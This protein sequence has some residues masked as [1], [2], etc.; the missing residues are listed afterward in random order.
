MTFPHPDLTPIATTGVAS[1]F[2]LDFFPDCSVVATNLGN[3]VASQP[4]PL[5]FLYNKVADNQAGDDSL[6]N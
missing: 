1:R 6:S 3:G 4:A 2:R 5:V